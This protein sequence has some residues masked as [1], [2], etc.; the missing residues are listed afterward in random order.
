MYEPYET[1]PRVPLII[2]VDR[3]IKY[4]GMWLMWRRFPSGSWKIINSSV[5]CSWGC[6]SGDEPSDQNSPFPITVN[7]VV[8]VLCR[9]SL[10]GY[11]GTGYFLYISVHIFSIC[12]IWSYWYQ[13][14]TTC[15]YIWPDCVWRNKL[16][17]LW[18]WCINYPSCNDRDNLVLVV[19]PK[20][21]LH[22]YLYFLTGHSLG[23]F[24][25][26]DCIGSPFDAII[27]SC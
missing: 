19:I 1:I 9:T 8:V 7:G 12:D 20:M 18:G 13:I 2:S 24:H 6:V 11:N 5:F 26:L 4:S 16:H 17:S 27:Q 21:V 14:P 25:L 10:G 15:L 3:H 23:N 22:Y